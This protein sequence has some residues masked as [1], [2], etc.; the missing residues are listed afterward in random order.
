M[1]QTPSEERR[2]AYRFNRP[3]MIVSLTQ[4]GQSLAILHVI[5]MSTSGICLEL[6]Q[7]PAGNAA[8]FSFAAPETLKG[9]K[10]RAQKIF[11]KKT[12]ASPSAYRL[13]YEFIIESPDQEQKLNRWMMELLRQDKSY[14][15]PT[16]VLGSSMITTG[17]E[18]PAPWKIRFPQNE[19]EYEQCLQLIRPLT[20]HHALIQTKYFIAFEVREVVA[21]ALLIPSRQEKKLPADDLF[22]KTLTRVRQTTGSLGEI[23]LY[24]DSAGGSPLNKSSFYLRRFAILRLLF[25]GLL[26]YAKYVMGFTK[27]ILC[28]P[29]YLEEFLRLWLFEHVHT[30]Q[31]QAPQ[32][33]RSFFS[34]PVPPPKL[35]TLMS[36]D[37]LN[38]EQLSHQKNLEI[39]EVLSVTRDSKTFTAQFNNHHQPSEQ[40]LRKYFGGVIK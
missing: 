20:A 1:Q 12:I 32:K 27:L 21:A 37:L 11:D 19:I 29:T 25:P 16:P 9:L 28:P 23:S 40:I 2:R 26:A 18:K 13:G 30:D 34:K 10:I 38:F 4:Q 22:P 3:N 7:P 6:S 24:F 35:G 39:P 17:T 14:L 31:D 15:P 5:D 36:V 8:E 33:K